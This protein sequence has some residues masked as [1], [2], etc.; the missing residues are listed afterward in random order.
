MI[1][2]SILSVI[3]VTVNGVLK[4]N[5][6]RLRLKYETD[7][8]APHSSTAPRTPHAL[9]GKSSSKDP[10]VLRLHQLAVEYRGS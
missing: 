9:D 2:Q 1:L 6:W 5:Q 7:A 4:A 8:L 3:S 10:P